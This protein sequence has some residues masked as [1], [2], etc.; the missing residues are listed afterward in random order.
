MPTFN[1]KQEYIIIPEKYSLKDFFDYRDEY[2][3]RP[4][5][6]RKSVWQPKKQQN[7]FDS[8]IRRYY[9]PRL[10]IREVRLSDDKTV[11]E[12]IDG[13]QRITA[14]IDF[15]DN[16]FKLP[17]SL[18]DVHK[19]FANKYYKD[20]SAELRR[21][22]DKELSINIDVVKNIENPNDPTHQKI[23]TEIFW[24]LQQGETLTFMEIAHAKLSSLSRNFIVKYS[25]DEEFDYKNYKPIDNNFN[26]HKF[27]KI[28]DLN[29]DR[30]QHLALMARF[31]IIEEADG[32]ADLKT[33]EVDEYI[34]KYDA[35]DGIGNY[36]FE[37]SPIAKKCISNLNL[38]YD[39]FKD[40]SMLSKSNGIK[41]LSKEY[42][43]ISFYI[44]LRYL[45][46]NYVIDT[47]EKIFLKEFFYNFNQKLL[48]N[49]QTNIDTV[50]F[51][52]NRQQSINNLQERDIVIRQLFFEYLLKNN[53]ELKTF[54]KKRTFNESDKIKIYRRDKGLCKECI[55]EGKSEKEATVTWAN[56][57]ADHIFPYSNGGETDINN[58]QV[59][60]SYHNKKKSNNVIPNGV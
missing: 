56:Y 14:I 60:C 35:I 24:R 44:L 52:N 58:G 38:F 34:K 27:F 30:M 16:K 1:P 8:F 32:Y 50:V 53:I 21:F 13:Q 37:D 46:E 15:Y 54:D 39:I 19:D 48:D 22:V 40:D 29:N 28:I 2:I 17:E 47:Q 49:D 10:I 55:N 26:K 45:K 3:I 51:T 33:D 4:A 57:Q 36:S 41:E 42:V 23:A 9:V 7:L 25:D 18:S 59:L 20:L 43:I 6:Q 11:N 31:L 12:V 5:Y